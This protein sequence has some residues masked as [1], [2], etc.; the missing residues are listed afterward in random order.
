MVWYGMYIYIYICRS[1]WVHVLSMYI[2]THT[3]LY[4]NVYV[5]ICKYAVICNAS[6]R[7]RGT[8][9]EERVDHDHA[10]PAGAW[11]FSAPVTSWR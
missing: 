6:P 7:A 1:I 10:S 11:P 5:G 8:S 3:H 9:W 4:L 2:H